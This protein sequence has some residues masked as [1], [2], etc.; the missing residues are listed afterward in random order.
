MKPSEVAKMMNDYEWIA[1]EKHLFGQANTAYDFKTNNPKEAGQRL[2]KLQEKKEKLGRNVNMRAMNMLTQ[3]EERFIVVSLKD[4][5]FNNSN[6]LFKTKF[7]DGV[8]TVG[9]F[10][11]NQNGGGSV[12]Q[13]KEK[14]KAKERRNRMEVDN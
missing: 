9:R 7:V 2:Q 10:A 14:R 1:S 13:Q 3:A 11:Q 5:M 12:G 8:S 6:V 4:S